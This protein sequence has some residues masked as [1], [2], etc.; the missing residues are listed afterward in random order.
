MKATATGNP[1]G[2]REILACCLAALKNHVKRQTLLSEDLKNV[3]KTESCAIEIAQQAM[4]SEQRTCHQ[5]LRRY[6]RA[7]PPSR[8]GLTSH[9]KHIKPNCPATPAACSL[10]PSSKPSSTNTM[11]AADMTSEVDVASSAAR[12]RSG[13]VSKKPEKFAAS[14]PTNSAK[15]KRGDN[16][17]SG[18]EADQPSSDEDEE[19]SSEGE[20]DEEELRERQ[21][22]RKGKVPAKR[23]AA[24]KPKTN[25]ATMSLAMRPAT[26][27]PKKIAKR[28]RKA[29]IRKSAVSAEEPA[30]LY[31]MQPKWGGTEHWLTIRSGRVCQRRPTGRCCSQVGDA[32]Q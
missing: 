22:K 6:G 31:G 3:S 29:A 19:E 5:P 12:R 1:K 30:G 14:S 7:D 9:P 24:K 8:V 25:G 11:S 18:V 32:L 15:R 10:H 21:R 26:S 27:A 17:D 13:R 2:I 20:P 16:D 23:P 4:M 28:P